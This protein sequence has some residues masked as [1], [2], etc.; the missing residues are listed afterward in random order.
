M[1]YKIKKK[2]KKID[3]LINNASYVGSDDKDFKK[4]RFFTTKNMRI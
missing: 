3:V 1:V 4:I 2:Y